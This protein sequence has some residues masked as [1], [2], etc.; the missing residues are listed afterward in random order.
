MI[1]F[2]EVNNIQFRGFGLHSNMYNDWHIHLQSAAMYL[3]VTT[4]AALTDWA[5]VSTVQDYHRLDALRAESHIRCFAPE[6]LT[7]ILRVNNGGNSILN[8][9][10]TYHR[11]IKEPLDT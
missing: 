3:P 2:F 1:S 7:H 10:K 4:S 9:K 6:G 8:V 11:L 5:A